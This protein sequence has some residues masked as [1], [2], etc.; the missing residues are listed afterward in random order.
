M[1]YLSCPK[2]SK[3]LLVR[4]FN[5]FGGKLNQKIDIVVFASFIPRH[6]ITFSTAVKNDKPAGFNLGG[7]GFH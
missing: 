3:R 1:F 4:G 2:K 5:R 6:F 7:D